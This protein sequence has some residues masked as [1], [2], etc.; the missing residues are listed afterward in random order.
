MV[1]RCEIDSRAL[2]QGDGVLRIRLDEHYMY[3]TGK[4]ATVEFRE[5]PT[6]YVA[7]RPSTWSDAQGS[8]NGLFLLG[9]NSLGLIFH[10]DLGPGG[11]P[12]SV[13]QRASFVPWANIVSFTQPAFED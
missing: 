13:P 6:F 12:D 7:R 5:A 2:K 8:V 9:A 11:D 1:A 3:M 4:P 10:A